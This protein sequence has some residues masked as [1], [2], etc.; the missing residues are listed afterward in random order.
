MKRVFVGSWK[1]KDI[2]PS[3]DGKSQKVKVKV[4]VNLHG[5]MTVSSATL[6][7][8]K[9]AAEQEP[10]EEQPEPPEPNG[11]EQKP[12]EAES[13][14][15]NAAAAGAPPEVGPSWTKRI[16]AWFGRVR[17]RSE[18]PAWHIFF[19]YP[20]ILFFVFCSHRYRTLTILLAFLVGCFF[21]LSLFVAHDVP[22]TIR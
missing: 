10:M 12:T 21:C 13:A 9:E 5:I 8:S 22:N 19:F 18:A 17:I 3:A 11:P 15:E 1:I 2:K 20:P 16:S 7:E 4:R 6:I 14:A